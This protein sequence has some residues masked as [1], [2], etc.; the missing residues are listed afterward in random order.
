[1]KELQR[2]RGSQWDVY[3]ADRRR[4]WIPGRSSLKSERVDAYSSLWFLFVAFD[5]LCLILLGRG[6]YQGVLVLVE[7]Y[8]PAGWL[9]ARLKG[10][11]CAIV[12]C[13]TYAI[14]LPH[15]LPFFH[16]VLESADAVIPISN[17]T[18]KRMEGAGIRAKYSVV[19]LGVDTDLFHPVKGTEKRREILFVG[20]LKS[21]KG[22]DF[23]IEATA[24]ANKRAPGIKLKIVGKIDKKSPAFAA[25]SKKIQDAGVDAEFCD[26]LSHDQLLH[27]YAS[28]RLNALP[29]KSDGFYYEGFGLIHL[30]AG[31]CGTLTVGTMDS[32]NEDAVQAGFGRL[33]SYGDVEAL[34]TYILEAMAINPYP[35]LPVERLRTWIDVAR[36]YHG[37]LTGL[38]RPLN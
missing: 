30:E 21:R 38:A 20:N 19:P 37:I 17:Y 12:Q 1:M 7:H 13:G 6:R 3:T 2:I 8:A 23:L 36:D 34:A 14:K 5:L 10:I 22:I 32:G 27:A 26:S 24:L 9:F 16:R 29:S 28:A 35:S 11:P 31:A 15:D 18:K 33:V 4:R 25:V